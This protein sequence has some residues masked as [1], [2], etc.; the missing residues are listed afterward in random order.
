MLKYSQ[1]HHRSIQMKSKI[2]FVIVLF[3]MLLNIFHDLIVDRQITLQST[4]LIEHQKIKKITSK[5]Q[6]ID[7][8][9]IF[10][11]SAVMMSYKSIEFFPKFLRNLD[12]TKK[13]SPFLVL[14]SSFKPPRV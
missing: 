3:A 11:F 8:H 10:H 13:L 4:T 7:L 2:L 1:K 5:H 12:F 6:M 9:E 14:H